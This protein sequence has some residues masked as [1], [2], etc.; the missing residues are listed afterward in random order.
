M[1]SIIQL[2]KNQVTATVDLQYRAKIRMRYLC[3]GV[4]VLGKDWQNWSSQIIFRR[5]FYEPSFPH[6]PILRKAPIS[7]IF[8]PQQ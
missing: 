5:K 6:L 8:I 4:L 3:S 2:H 1:L 7:K